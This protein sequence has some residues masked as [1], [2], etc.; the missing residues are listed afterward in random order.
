[1]TSGRDATITWTSY[2]YPAS[3]ANGSDTSSFSYTP[4]APVLEANFELHERRR[5]D[6]DLRGRHS[7]KGDDER[8][9][10][11]PAHDPR[12][13]LHD[14]R[15]PT[16]LPARTAL[17]TSPRTISAVVPLS[18]TARAVC[19]STR[20]SMPMESAGHRTGLE[21]RAQVIGPISRATTRRGYT[22]HSMLDNLGLIHMGGRVHDP[23]LGRFISAD[24]YITYPGM[25]QSYNRYSY[26]QNNPLSRIRPER[27]QRHRTRTYTIVNEDREVDPLASMVG[28]QSSLR[29]HHPQPYP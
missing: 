24:P 8:G 15:L 13:R 18:P 1:M 11:L 7:R 12:G 17:I 21:A 23:V 29:G 26:V 10:R 4:D 3:I 6:D 16:R 14:H 25:T 20:A 19:S 22:D 5:R 2:N 9:H 27:L 28:M